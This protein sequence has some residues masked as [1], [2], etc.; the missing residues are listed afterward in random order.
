MPPLRYQRD[1]PLSV[2]RVGGSANAAA[3]LH[4]EA[5]QRYRS[6]AALTYKKPEICGTEIWYEDTTT[7]T[8]Y[9]V[10][11]CQMCI[12]PCASI[13]TVSSAVVA[14]LHQGAWEFNCPWYLGHRH[15]A[16]NGCSTRETI[17]RLRHAQA[18]AFCTFTKSICLAQV[19]G[20]SKDGS[21][22][23]AWCAGAGL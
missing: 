12:S 22:N 6:S 19:R 20:G 4:G 2:K 15:R 18:V 3:M 23:M 1:T 17:G 5:D 9:H 14:A 8:R 16:R 11:H 7:K 10:P 13:K 21:V